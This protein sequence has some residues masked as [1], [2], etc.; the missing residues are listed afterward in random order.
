[1]GKLL[2]KIKEKTEAAR[3]YYKQVIERI[4]NEHTF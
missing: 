1:V 4:A 3:E 2:E